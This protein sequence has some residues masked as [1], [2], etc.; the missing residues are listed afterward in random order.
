MGVEFDSRNSD[1]Y[2]LTKR[3]VGQFY[4]NVDVSESSLTPEKEAHN[5]P[6][7]YLDTRDSFDHTFSV[8]DFMINSS[9][10][11]TEKK[12]D[13]VVLQHNTRSENRSQITNFSKT[14]TTLKE[15]NVN[16]VQV[17]RNLFLQDDL[18]K[19]P[20]KMTKANKEN[21]VDIHEMKKNQSYEISSTLKFSTPTK[22]IKVDKL[23]YQSS[24]QS[25]IIQTEI[26]RPVQQVREPCNCKKS[27]C[28]KG[29]CICFNAGL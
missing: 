8:F 17:N 23:F 26:K 11:I 25:S 3:E 19:N 5:I 13:K 14:I 6:Y 2:S 24:A 4:K 16:Q 15:I 1:E 21:H 10:C 28:L 7:D 20:K 12:V 18:F 27:Q 29:Y 22:K 9:T